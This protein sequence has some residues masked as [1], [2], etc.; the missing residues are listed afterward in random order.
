MDDFLFSSNTVSSSNIGCIVAVLQRVS[1]DGR[2]W[3][4]SQHA[5]GPNYV[6]GRFSSGIPALSQSSNGGSSEDLIRS[7]ILAGTSH[8]VLEWSSDGVQYGLRLANS[9]ESV[10]VLAGTNSGDWFSNT[11]SRDNWTIG[12]IMYGVGGNISRHPFNCRIAYLGVFDSPLLVQDRYDL[13]KW[14]QDYYGITDMPGLSDYEQAVLTDAPSAFWPMQETSG[15]IVDTTGN[16][17]IGTKV[18][19]GGVT[20]GV[21]GPIAG[22][23]AIE[24]AD[25]SGVGYSVADNNLWS[26]TNFTVEGWIYLATGF[27]GAQ[28]A[29][30]FLTKHSSGVTNEWFTA[31]ENVSGRRLIAQ[32]CNFSDTNWANKTEGPNWGAENTWYHVAWKLSGSTVTLYVNGVA[33]GSAASAYGTRAGNASGVLSIGYGLAVADRSWNG[34]MAMVAFYPQALSDSQILAYYQAMT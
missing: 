4:S 1:G 24:F 27:F 13:Y 12:A 16:G 15:D 9:T 25:S 8:T 29:R 11:L 3:S 26:S 20:Y 34:R 21:G 33:V 7:Q 6:I 19:S 23:G 28:P 14:I 31:I 10:S 18:G 5:V 22:V 2:V 17:F 32:V 30:Y